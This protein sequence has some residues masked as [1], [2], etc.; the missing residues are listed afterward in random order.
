MILFVMMAMMMMID[1]DNDDDNNDD[2]DKKTTTTTALCT[3]LRSV[4]AQPTSEVLQSP[5]HI[6]LTV[7]DDD[8]GPQGRVPHK[9]IPATTHAGTSAQH[10]R[11]QVSKDRQH[12]IVR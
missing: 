9:V 8:G 10:V 7:V 12:H 6:H 2:D 11:R 3:H 1:D 5:V 4:V